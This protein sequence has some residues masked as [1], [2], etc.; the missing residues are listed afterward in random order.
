MA[1]FKRK[2]EKAKYGF[3]DRH[4][5]GRECW[6]PGMYQHRSMMAGGGS[7]NTGSPDTPCCMNRAY[8]GCPAGPV[9]ET[10]EK[11]YECKGEGVI[12]NLE[13]QGE[14]PQFIPCPVCIGYKEIT[15]QGLPLVSIELSKERKS[16]GWTLA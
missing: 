4:C 14:G 9:G 6:S 2:G 3:A 10:K 16:Q 5:I 7:R 11:C 8:R 13:F 1:Y 15:I 12:P